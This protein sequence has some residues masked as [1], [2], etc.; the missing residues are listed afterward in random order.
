MYKKYQDNIHRSGTLA[1]EILKGLAEGE[2]IY[3][4]FLKAVEAIGLMTN[5][6]VILA[7]AEGYIETVYGE[8]LGEPEPL[9]IQLQAVEKRLETLEESYLWYD[10]PEEKRRIQ[11]AIDAHYRKADKLRELIE[12]SKA[13]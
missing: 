7:Q 5:D 6:N 1:S 4:L 2:D 9:Q 8:S 11:R 3:S 10:E 13:V 12:G